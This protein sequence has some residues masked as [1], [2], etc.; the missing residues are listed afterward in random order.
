[1]EQSKYL[2]TSGANFQGLDTFPVDPG[3]QEI[4]MTSDEVTALCP[5]T[6]HPDQYT[7]SILYHP[8][9]LAIE[10]K[11]LK[12]YFQTFRNQGIFCE[13]F[14]AQIAR[15]VHEVTQAH[16][17]DVWVTQKPRGGI[18]IVAHATAGE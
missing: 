14:A 13:S 9:A 10:S 4:T 12:L 7:V 11:S 17:V 8:D 1:M 15:D 2:G 16:D 3:V 18:E 5:V 6:G